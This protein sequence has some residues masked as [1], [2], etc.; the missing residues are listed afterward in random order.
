VG[1]FDRVLELDPV[2]VA[3]AR[4]ELGLV[5]S[6]TLEVVVGDAR[7]SI[8]DEP[9]D[10]YDL[11]L[12]D[13]FSGLSV[14]WHLATRELLVEVHRVLDADGVYAINLIDYPPLGFARAELATFRSVFRHVALI[15]PSE[16]VRGAA[17]GNFALLGSDMPIP[18]A[19]IRERNKARSDDDVVL[20]D[21]GE[22]AAFIGDAPVLSDDFAPVDQLLTP[23][24]P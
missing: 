6:P 1:S 16:R 22:L 11:V 4:E 17:G 15:A 19:A 18:A 2:V 13:A 8:A 9:D 10:T 20:D 23:A 21:P 24:R 14:P 5:T 7:L 3:V 12:G